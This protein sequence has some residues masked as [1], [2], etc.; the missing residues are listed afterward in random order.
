MPATIVYDDGCAFCRRVV[1]WVAARDVH[2]RFIALAC[3]SPERAA[4]FPWMGEARCLGAVQLVD[5]AGRTAEEAEVA[6]GRILQGLPRW[7]WLGRLVLLAPLRPLTA[8]GY[9]W[10]AG[11]RRSLGCGCPPDGPGSPGTAGGPADSAGVPDRADR[12][13]AGTA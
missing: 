10:V 12:G 11:H 3:R 7:G 4:R 5:E 6:V 1:D 13:G 8:W 2:A 9:R